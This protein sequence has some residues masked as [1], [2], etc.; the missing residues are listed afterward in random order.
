VSQCWSINAGGPGVALTAPAKSALSKPAFLQQRCTLVRVLALPIVVLALVSCA[1]PVP[2]AQASPVTVSSAT[3]LTCNGGTPLPRGRASATGVGGGSV[4]IFGGDVPQSANTSS[5]SNDTWVSDRGCWTEMSSTTAPSARTL[6]ALS[7]DPT[8][9]LAILYGGRYDEPGKYPTPLFDSWNW[10]G[11]AWAQQ[12]SGPRLV[13]PL[14]TYDP[15]QKRIILVGRDP[16]NGVGQTWAW[17][18]GAW[19]QLTTALQP[20]VADDAG[21][22]F[23]PGTGEGVYFGGNNPGAGITNDTWLWRSGDWALV[24][25]AAAPPQRLSLA[26]ICAKHPIMF[27]GSDGSSQLLTDLW[28]WT[29]TGW[30]QIHATHVPPARLAGIAAFDGSRGLLLGG[31]D[32]AGALLDVWAW[33]D[34]NSDWSLVA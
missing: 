23:D 11:S 15:I 13:S 4:L 26:L 29:T 33:N 17:S 7:F 34:A 31:S 9:G 32:R 14:S 1:P 25:G 21:F 19:T 28:T 12:P 2:S 20:N 10:N 5:S 8:S 24:T 6:A 18:S 16:Q 30:H 22:C 27:G 3:P